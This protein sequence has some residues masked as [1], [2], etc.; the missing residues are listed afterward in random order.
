MKNRSR[1]DIVAGILDPA[2]GGISKTRLLS[3][4]NLTSEQLRK[5]LVVLIEEELLLELADQDKRHVAYVT[6]D[7]GLRYL[8]LY[9][10]LK[11]LAV[12]PKG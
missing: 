10:S 9:S 6:T 5:Y 4:A 8:S 2:N 3:L 7:K 1:P 12:F 11:S